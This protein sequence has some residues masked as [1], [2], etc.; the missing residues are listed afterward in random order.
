MR[1][2]WQA[3]YSYGEGW[4]RFQFVVNLSRNTLTFHRSLDADYTAMIRALAGRPPGS[5]TPLPVPTGK[6]ESITLETEI[7][8]LKMSRVDAGAFQAGPSGDWLVV[9]AFVPRSSESFLLGVNDRLNAGEIVIARPEAVP[10]VIHALS[11][12]FG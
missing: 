6:V 3:I 1:R 9:Q 5:L 11:Q 10:A 2:R 8:G 7:V 4:S 12:V